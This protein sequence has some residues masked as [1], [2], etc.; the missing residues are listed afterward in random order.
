MRTSI[1]LLFVTL[2]FV[3][4]SS[5]AIQTEVQAPHEHRPVNTIRPGNG[6]GNS[7]VVP[8]P[9][10]GLGEETRRASLPSTAT[11]PSTNDWLDTAEPFAPLSDGRSAESSSSA[12]PEQVLGLEMSSSEERAS[13]TTDDGNLPATT[14]STDGPSWSDIASTPEPAEPVTQVT[15]EQVY[16]AASELPGLDTWTVVPLAHFRRGLRHVVVAWPAL[17]S[18]G[19]AVD[20]T[21]V[22]ICLE[23]TGGGGLEQCGSRWVITD[24][25]AA[26]TALEQAL[27][28]SDYEVVSRQTSSPLDDL[29]PRLAQLGN[30]FASAADRGDTEAARRAATTFAQLLPV[31]AVAF[32]NE[33]AQLLWMAARYDGQLEHVSTERDGQ[34]ATLTF[35]ANRGWIRVRTIRVIAQ[36]VNGDMSRWVVVDY[37]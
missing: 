1:T 21:V 35:D 4:C 22:G 36:P 3:G 9:F 28:G 8:E 18:T 27:G 19:E 25:A 23:E 13:T 33:L 14:L 20:A 2:F 26:T 11:T 7:L 10:D 29:G 31:D 24:R 5:R 34:F 17:R 16:A 30:D 37:R 6:I 32:D 12:A 15:T